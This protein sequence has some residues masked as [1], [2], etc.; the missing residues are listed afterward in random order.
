MTRPNPNNLSSDWTVNRPTNGRL[1]ALLCP[2]DASLFPF[3]E[4]HQR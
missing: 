3:L 2:L 4:C 1:L